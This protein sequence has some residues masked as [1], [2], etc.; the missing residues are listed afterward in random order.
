MGHTDLMRVVVTRISPD[1]TMGRR[2][3]DTAASTD[4]GPWEDLIARALAARRSTARF[5]GVRSTIFAQMS[6]LCWSPSTTCPGRC[7][8]WSLPCSPSARRYME[9]VASSPR[10]HY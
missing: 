5:R 9:P 8:T 7:T 6:R 10:G 4:A 3:V 2:M 1:G